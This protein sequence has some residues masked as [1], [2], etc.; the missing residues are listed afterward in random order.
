MEGVATCEIVKNPS[1]KAITKSESNIAGDLRF[2]N[3]LSANG[4]NK[5]KFRSLLTFLTY[6]SRRLYFANQT[7]ERDTYFPK[8]LV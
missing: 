7:V 6:I 4:E 5:R 8:S 1:E 3:Q 2:F